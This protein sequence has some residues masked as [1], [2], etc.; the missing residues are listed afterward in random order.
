MV[1]KEHWWL[2]AGLTICMFL[3]SNAAVAQV[4]DSSVSAPI[5]PISVATASDAEVIEEPDRPL[6]SGWYQVGTAWRYRNGFYDLKDTWIYEDGQ[7]YYLDDAGIMAVGSW[8]I[9]EQSY[10]FADNGALYRD[11]A[12]E[13]FGELRNRDAQGSPC[14]GYRTIQGSRYYFTEDGNLLRNATTPDGYYQVNEDGK[15]VSVNMEQIEADCPLRDAPGTSGYTMGGYPVE[16][17]MV[18][19]AGET[20]GATIIMGDRS[21]A[22]GMCQFDYRYDLV[23]FMEYAYQTHPHLWVGFESLIGKYQ[24]GDPEL[25][26]NMDI[27]SAFQL[28]HDLSPVNY[29]ADQAEFLYHRYFAHTYQA[30]EATGYGLSQRNIA[31]SA[32]IMSVNINCGPQTSLYLQSLSPDMSDEEIVQKIY[33]LRNTILTRNGKGTN[34]RFRESEPR[35]AAELLNGDITANSSFQKAGGVAW[36]PDALKYC[37]ESFS[38]EEI[39]IRLEQMKNEAET[40]EET[41]TLEETELG[42]DIEAE[43]E[44]AEPETSPVILV[45]SGDTIE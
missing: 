5:I 8:V 18:S 35:L 32:A 28:A 24:K 33:S 1:T 25:V 43:V 41:E 44:E 22:Y 40:A 10:Q 37:G 7:L 6:A 17:F 34:T 4:A 45:G 36:G 16:L 9:D 30:M 42:P 39:Q 13:E 2:F 29:A 23:D 19:M 38:E 31:V 20:S 3:G 27:L 26:G 14:S 11:G 21:R 12:Y 15:I